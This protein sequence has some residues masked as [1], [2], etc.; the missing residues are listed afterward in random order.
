MT[1]NTLFTTTITNYLLQT[2][3]LHYNIGGA[4]V[5]ESGDV[6]MSCSA[7]SGD[8]LGV[9]ELIRVPDHLILRHPRN[10]R[11]TPHGHNGPLATAKVSAGTAA[12]YRG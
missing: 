3:R 10:P 2:P 6:V 11:R 9:A 4:A 7:Q 12:V 1:L 8:E 5:V